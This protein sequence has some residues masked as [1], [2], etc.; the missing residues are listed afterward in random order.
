MLLRVADGPLI[1]PVLSRVASMVL[2]RANCPV[3]RLDDAL[4]LCDAIAAHAPAHSRDGHISFELNAVA[5]AIE[6]RVSELRPGGASKLIEDAQLPSVGNV[7]ERFS[8]D[9]RIEQAADG[10]GEELVL[11]LGFG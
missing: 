10:D 4:V 8:D 3:D 5:G 9:R 11:K 7:I 1:A 2:A 6:L